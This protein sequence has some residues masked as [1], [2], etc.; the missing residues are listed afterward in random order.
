MLEVVNIVIGWAVAV[1]SLSL[2]YLVNVLFRRSTETKERA[3]RK[4]LPGPLCILNVCPI[5]F[6]RTLLRSI[7]IRNR[8][9]RLLWFLALTTWFTHVHMALV[10]MD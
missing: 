10:H 8:F 7:H 1:L 4:R 3:K 2:V 6:P 9:H 5:S